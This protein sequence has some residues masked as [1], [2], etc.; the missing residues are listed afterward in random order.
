MEEAETEHKD[1]DIVEDLV[2]CFH[3]FHNEPG[4]LWW[5]LQKHKDDVHERVVWLLV[6]LQDEHF[7]EFP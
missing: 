2:Q 5:K 1:P 7:R 6:G 3:G 4:I